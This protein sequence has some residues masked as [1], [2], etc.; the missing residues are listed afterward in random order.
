M[1][2]RSNLERVTKKRFL[3]SEH[4]YYYYY[5]HPLTYFY[6]QKRENINRRIYDCLNVLGAMGVVER[7]EEVQWLGDPQPDEVDN[8]MPFLLSCSLI[9]HLSF[10]RK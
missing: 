1:S 10:S 8:I 6:Q 5:I 7:T 3:R 2:N 9:H 4:S